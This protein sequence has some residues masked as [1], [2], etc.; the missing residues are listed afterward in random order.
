MS[1]LREMVRKSPALAVAVLS[2]F[3]AVGGG[4]GY[5]ASTV[6]PGVAA[7]GTL[8]FHPLKLVRPFTGSL[9][10]AVVGDVMYLN[11]VVYTKQP[12]ATEIANLPKEFDRA[13][14]VVVP[15]AFGSNHGP[16]VSF[17]GGIFVGGGQIDAEPPPGQKVA[18][19]WLTGISFLLRR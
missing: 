11:G 7:S 15:A 6:Q 18:T 10:Y 13:Q 3:F 16:I 8:V 14:V 5:A 1:R 19:V 9:A 12:N 17:D 4:A 2:L